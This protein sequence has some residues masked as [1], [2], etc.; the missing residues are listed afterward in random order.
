MARL[1]RTY[2]LISGGA[3]RFP[4][5]VPVI[6]HEWRRHGA[7]DGLGGVSAGALLSVLLSRGD[8]SL[9]R[10]LCMSVDKRKE[11]L[12]IPLDGIKDGLVSMD[13]GRRLVGQ[14]IKG[15]PAVIPVHVGI[16]DA[17]DSI[18]DPRSRQVNITNM[19]DRY[20]LDCVFASASLS[21][22][23]EIV[24]YRWKGEDRV[25]YD[26]GWLEVLPRLRAKVQAGDRVVAMFHSP[27]TPQSR[28]KQ[29]TQEDVSDALGLAAAEFDT[30][31]AR[32][33]LREDMPYLQSLA[34]RGVIVDV[35]APESWD[36]VG[37]SWSY[38]VT[39]RD[40]RLAAG[41]R[42]VARGPIRL[43]PRR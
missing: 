43:E 18:A 32:N 16:V 3:L 40:H 8:V 22:V 7:P 26:G 27:V 17:V 36:D 41:D 37:P 14:A 39:W 2:W 24:T 29:L 31:M 33:V 42:A 12:S 38:D 28:D 15:K 6:E 35:Y 21:P 9:P 1:S 25:G 34:D 10:A 4:L 5:L 20:A 19:R 30:L 11:M 13:R 23:M